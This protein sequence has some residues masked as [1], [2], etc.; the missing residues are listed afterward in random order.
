[1]GLVLHFERFFRRS[2]FLLSLLQV[3]YCHETTKSLRDCDAFILDFC[4]DSINA[5]ETCVQS[6]KGYS[7]CFEEAR[8]NYACFAKAEKKYHDASHF[9]KGKSRVEDSA[10]L[11][12]V[13]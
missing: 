12:S 2:F 10:L 7:A 9:I 6:R 8:L 13:I 1:M 11:N 3:H 5:H 4:S